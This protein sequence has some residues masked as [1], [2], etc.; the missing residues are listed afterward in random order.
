MPAQDNVGLGSGARGLSNSGGNYVFE[1]KPI[2]PL[3]C[4]RRN[5]TLALVV[6]LAS[7]FPVHAAPDVKQ[8]G[9]GLYA[10]ISDNDSSANS[11]FL[12]GNHGIL[13]V[14]TGL[15]EQE[16]RKI[17]EAIRN[18]S[19]LPVE[20]IVNTHYHPDHQGGN[21]VFGPGAA[22]ISTEWTRKRILE[23][24][25][26]LPGKEKSRF[27]LADLT[28]DE[29][30]TIHLDP[31]TAEVYFP[32]KAHT[33]GD[34]LVYLPQ[35][36]AIAMGDLFLNR[37]SPA[38]DEGS[39]KTWIEA[40]DRVLNLPIKAVVPGHFELA[41][42]SEL[43][44]FRNYLNDLYQ[45]VLALYNQG[46]SVEQV[47]QRMH[48]DQYQDFRQYPQFEATFADNAATIYQQ[49]KAQR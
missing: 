42:A 8:I 12:I 18:V 14:D 10:Y 22:I 41:G 23:L 38:M 43:R 3:I 24:I 36:Q 46:A 39:V 16:G 21:T 6:L 37:S 48:M 27:Q 49:L 9:E 11:T 25:A 33:S 28:F 30:I 4:G 32:G 7:V 20:Y 2:M 45:Q 35:Q 34:A 26:S 44:R 17:L 47:R 29:K 1:R 13:V 15:N 5:S 19:S 31:Y 40:L